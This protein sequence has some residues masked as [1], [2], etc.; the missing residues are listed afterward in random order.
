MNFV[1][2]SALFFAVTSGSIGCAMFWDV[3]GSPLDAA[4]ARGDVPAIRQLVTS[5]ADVNAADD[6][7]ATALYWAARGGHRV[8]PHRCGDEADGRPGVLAALLDLGA[9]PNVQDRRPQGFGRASG[10]T[11]LMVALH[12]QQ[13]KSARL[14]LERGA[15]P[16]ILSDQGM[17]VM[18][19]ASAER[20]PQDLMSLIV[21]KGFAADRT[22]RRAD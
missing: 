16:N 14:L 8:G 2:R 21:A 20:A 17:S 7:G 22:H 3:P 5:G 18:T 15:D 10:W 12:H 9:N 4:A 1:L 6:M 19:M 11:P 13:F